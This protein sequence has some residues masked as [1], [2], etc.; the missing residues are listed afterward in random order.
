MIPESGQIAY[1][2][3][4]AALNSLTKSM[5]QE[6]R[7][8][9]INVNAILPAAIDTGMSSEMSQKSISEQTSLMAHKELI[10]SNDVIE[11]ILFLLENRAQSITGQLIR[12]DNGIIF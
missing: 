1:G 3:S 7:R 6:Y 8:N 4:K 5:A 9:N 12:V 11:L 10:E 2:A